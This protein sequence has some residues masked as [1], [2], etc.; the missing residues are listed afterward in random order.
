MTTGQ[1]YFHSS[2]AVRPLA[3]AICFLRW[4][5][6]RALSFAPALSHLRVTKTN[7]IASVIRAGPVAGNDRLDGPG[8][9]LLPLR[10]G[11]RLS[12]SAAIKAEP[13]HDAWPIAFDQHIGL[14]S[15]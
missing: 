3:L 13:L 10:W 15:P 14:R 11:S 7:V 8:V 5:V 1:P 2:R 6:V 12:P 4:A 9:P